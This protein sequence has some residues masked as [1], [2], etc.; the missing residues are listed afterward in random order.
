MHPP[1]SWSS[2]AGYLLA[3]LPGVAGLFDLVAMDV[4]GAFAVTLFADAGPCSRAAFSPQ[5]SAGNLALLQARYNDRPHSRA[6]HD[7]MIADRDGSNLRRLF[8]P[9]GQPGLAAQEITWSPDGQQLAL[10][11]EEQLLLLDVTGGDSQRFPFPGKVTAVV[12]SN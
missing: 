7:L 8:P 6:G 5:R 11:H 3:R 9:A 2:D 10:V 1:L 4:S 12:W